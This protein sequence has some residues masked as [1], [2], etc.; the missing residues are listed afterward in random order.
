M[1]GID[2]FTV[3][4]WIEHLQFVYQEIRKDLRHGSNYLI[5]VSTLFIASVFSIVSNTY[6]SMGVIGM[7]VSLLFF[8]IIFKSNTNLARR[9]YD[10]ENL[11]NKIMMGQITDIKIIRNKFKNISNKY[12]PIGNEEKAI[13]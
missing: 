5:S 2:K 13:E 6:L 8:F 3:K 9:S 12:I 1:E 4:D 10:L 7:L 11:L